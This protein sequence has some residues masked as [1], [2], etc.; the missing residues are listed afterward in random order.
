MSDDDSDN[1]SGFGEGLTGD[2]FIQ[3]RIARMRE[4]MSLA[5]NGRGSG[6]SDAAPPPAQRPA[7]AAAA[8]KEEAPPPPRAPEGPPPPPEERA[9]AVDARPPEGSVAAALTLALGSNNLDDEEDEEDEEEEDTYTVTWSEGQLG[10]LFT[11]NARGDTIIRRV[12]KR[13]SSAVGIHAARAGDVLLALD[14]VSVRGVPFQEIVER[15]RLPTFPVRLE[16]QPPSAALDDL[17]SVPGSERSLMRGPSQSSSVGDGSTV[18]PPSAPSPLPPA[19]SPPVET[20]PPAQPPPRDAD[21]P[22]P[23]DFPAAAALHLADLTLSNST[24]APAENEYD[25]VWRQGSLGCKLK[26]RNKLPTVLSATPAPTADTTV[27]LIGAGD[28]MIMINGQ[29]TDEIGFTAVIETLQRAPKPVFMRFRRT[30]ADN[31]AT[32]GEQEYSRSVRSMRPAVDGHGL[33]DSALGPGQY[34]VLWQGGS[35]GVQIKARSDGAVIVAKFTGTG[36]PQLCGQIAVGDVLVRIAGVEVASVGLAGAFELLKT[37]Q[38]PVVLIFGREIDSNSIPDNLR[39]SMVPSFRKLR[40]QEAEA[41]AHAPSPHRRGNSDLGVRDVSP[42]RQF[43]E[44]F[45]GFASEDVAARRLRPDGRPHSAQDIVGLDRRSDDASHH[46]SGL[47]RYSGDEYIHPPPPPQYPADPLP[48]PPSY[49][50]VFTQSGRARDLVSIISDD[51]AHPPA[52]PSI[53]QGSFDRIGGNLPPPPPYPGLS[54]A[55]PP[56]YDRVPSYMSDESAGSAYGIEEMRRRYIE[57][58]RRRN[59]KPTGSSLPPP[60]PPEVEELSS[61]YGHPQPPP[62]S[63]PHGPELW[64]RWSEGPLGITFRRTNGQIVVS[65]LTGAGQSPGME[66]LR[67]GDWLMSFGNPSV[68]TYVTRD[69]RLSETMDLIKKLPKPVDMCYVVR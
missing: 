31:S 60:Y 68:G 5:A 2:A 27:K 30:N 8:A 41:F 63:G 3:D 66:Q 32:A 64:I 65:R 45:S 56:A 33:P 48:P 55:A 54:A 42:R 29:R 53:S 40:E 52:S 62:A 11:S 26:Q 28:V 1:D 14:G 35:L 43:R 4:M 12:S 34:S 59:Q 46:S 24:S 22:P 67:P 61:P 38:K 10:L 13:T 57:E 18:A 39:S 51:A 6:G 9:P 19:Y 44:T 25:V 20:V 7:A 69:L 47:Q 50:D 15:L 36:D 23:Y 17:Q 49:L 16:F 21:A 58:E 37:V